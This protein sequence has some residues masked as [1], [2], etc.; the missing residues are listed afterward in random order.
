MF[1]IYFLSQMLF[2]IILSLVRWTIN[3]VARFLWEPFEFDES[4]FKQKEKED[5]KEH[6]QKIR[7]RLIK[8][9]ETI[10][11][12]GDSAKF[13]GLWVASEN[14]KETEKLFKSYVK[15]GYFLR[16]PGYPEENTKSFS[17]DM[18]AGYFAG[19]VS[20]YYR[21]TIDED[22][23]KELIKAID[24]AIFTRP[25]FQFK[26][27]NGKG[28]RGY[29]LRW[30][31][32]NAGHFLPLLSMCEIAYK[33]TRNKKYKLLYL[34]VLPVAFIDILIYPTFFIRFKRLRYS[35]WYYVHSNFTY[36]YYL[37]KLTGNPI[38]RYG[39]KFIYKRFYFNPEFAALT[40]NKEIALLFL[41][42][43]THK[44]KEPIP[45]EQIRVKNL[46]DLIRGK[47][48]D[49]LEFKKILPPRVIQND[50]LWEK[51][52]NEIQYYET[53]LAGIDFIRVYSLL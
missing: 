25:F 11:I 6:Y 13:V 26:T 3:T 45:V 28:N 40:G 34:A 20:L 30:F 37:Y 35:Q 18:W 33:L 14:T 51:P 29:L 8:N 52:F 4:L 23:K 39:Y 19:L 36:Y 12:R 38:Y 10:E 7:A 15:D 16:K 49:Y 48:A 44:N 53:P 31:F 46:K 9:I 22:Y 50:Y 2:L 43:Y 42:D 21:R 17:G 24:N 32:M 1:Y 47:K 27:P 5:L 41:K